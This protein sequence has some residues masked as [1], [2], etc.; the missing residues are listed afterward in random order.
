M[1]RFADDLVKKEYKVM[2]LEI[3]SVQRKLIKIKIDVATFEL[4]EVQGECAEKTKN[5]NKKMKQESDI[6]GK[7]QL[8]IQTSN[9][10]VS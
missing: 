3:E 5:K 1:T 4:S 8:L 2:Q 9:S 10:K 7:E 6:F